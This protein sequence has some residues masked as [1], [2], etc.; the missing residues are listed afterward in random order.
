MSSDDYADYPG[1][2]G[3]DSGDDDD[4][5]LPF[6]PPPPYLDPYEGRRDEF[7]R[8]R[9]RFRDDLFWLLRM[10]REAV[11]GHEVEVIDLRNPK[12]I[13][14]DVPLEHRLKPLFEMLMELMVASR[15]TSHIIGLASEQ[16]WLKDQLAILDLYLQQANSLDDIGTH[17]SRRLAKLS[18]AD[19][20]SFVRLHP[21]AA[22]YRVPE[23]ILKEHKSCAPED[24]D[25]SSSSD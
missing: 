8:K 7:I 1:F 16:M 15:D 19:A 13:D 17:A 18:R 23:K 14:D 22:N 5:Y 6:G 9:R 25:P 11:D 3:S 12:D 24:E 2:D 21:E 10:K 20:D 4:D